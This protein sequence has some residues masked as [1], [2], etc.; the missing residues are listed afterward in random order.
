MFSQR[1]PIK[2]KTDVT[3]EPCPDISLTLDFQGQQRVVKVSG[4]DRVEAE[5]GTF[6]VGVK[7]LHLERKPNH[8]PSVNGKDYYH[9]TDDLGSEHI[10]YVRSVEN[11]RR[12]FKNKNPGRKIVDITT[13]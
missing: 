9:I 10:E 1:I 12:M 8:R 11:A 5:F 6:S 3:I 7:L 2:Q 13:K 4:K